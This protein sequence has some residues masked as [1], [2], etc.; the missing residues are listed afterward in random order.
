MKDQLIKIAV[1]LF[2]ILFPHFV[3]LPF[4]SYTFVCLAAI[5]FYLRKNH[6]TIRELGLKKSD[7]TQS[8][9]YAGILSALL[10]S[11]FNQLFYIPIV[12]RLFSAPDYVEFNSIRNH[13]INLVISVVAA[14]F[15]GGFYEE[16]VFRGFIHRQ[17]EGWFKKEKNSFWK[18]GIVT[19]ALFGL[20]HWQQG[21]FG[22]L[23]AAL[24]G[25]FWTYLL[26]RY[27]GNLWPAIVSH[28]TYDTIALITIYFDVFGFAK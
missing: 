10:W 14:W 2:L 25:L 12:V 17:F 13:P 27:K 9:F 24:G 26:D 20:Y 8:V 11:L 7:L 16:L 22:I 23:A 19:S 5:V 18:A 15:I 28:A 3:P 6:H 1:I 21:I 4:Y